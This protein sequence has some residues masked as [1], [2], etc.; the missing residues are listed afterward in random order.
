MS[1][2]LSDF[3]NED[4]IKLT[5]EEIRGILEGMYREE[6]KKPMEFKTIAELAK[7]YDLE[8]LN[9]TWFGATD[10]YSLVGEGLEIVVRGVI[11]DEVVIGY[12]GHIMYPDGTVI[13]TIPRVPLDKM[14]EWLHKEL[15][16]ASEE[17]S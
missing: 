15:Q 14:L 3:I 6:T 12:N 5:N 13:A 4:N 2:I 9:S 10:D 1:I 8:V 17:W 11:K 7:Y 16:E